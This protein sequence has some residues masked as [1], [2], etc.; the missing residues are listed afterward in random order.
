MYAFNLKMILVTCLALLPGVII[1]E[2]SFAEEDTANF[3]GKNPS[4][5]QI[6][7]ALKPKRLGK[8]RGVSP[9]A[10]TSAG[11][12]AAPSTMAPAKASFDQITFQLNSDRIVDDAKSIL[13]R[14]GKALNSEELYDVSFL[15][16]GHTD[17]SGSLQYNMRLSERRAESVK[18]YL[19]ENF[20]VDPARLK[21]TGKGPTD[22]LD[23]QNPNSARN[24]RVVFAAEE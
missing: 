6:I 21:T 10:V 24:R 1:T 14:L 23:K 17:V 4:E 11:A 2:V 7:N 13:D 16:E 5:E 3:S 18:H 20:H 19:T 22:L 9:G 12:A 8:S 15:I